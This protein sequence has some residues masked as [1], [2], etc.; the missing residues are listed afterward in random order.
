[1]TTLKYCSWAAY[2]ICGFLLVASVVTE[3]FL[4][5]VPAVTSAICGILFVAFD[6][7]VSL[8]SEIRDS[9]KLTALAG[10]ATAGLD[11]DEPVT[12]VEASAASIARLTANLEAAKRRQGTS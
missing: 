12:S 6:R 10:P 1:M 9:L 4:L 7:I 3:K 2:A 8:L 5:I 11:L